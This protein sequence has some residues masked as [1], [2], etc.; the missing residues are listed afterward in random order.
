MVRNQ[1]LV[2]Q[3]SMLFI[4]CAILSFGMYN[5]HA[6]CQI[7][8]GGVLGLALLANHWLGIS[9][10]LSG[11]LLDIIC[12]AVALRQFGKRFFLNAVAASLAY[13]VFYIIWEFTGPLLPDLSGLPLLAAILGGMFVGIGVGLVVRAGGASGGDDVLALLLAQKTK[14][15]LAK[16]YFIFDASVLVL[17]LSYIPLGRILF[18]LV[19]VTVSSTLIDKISAH[20][21]SVSSV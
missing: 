21:H 4:G 13:S 17:S 18:S 6:R 8:E 15:S 7:T 14:L 9:P 19:T 2:K 11:P 10:G 3:M 5:I 20:R 16:A 12:Y 1:K